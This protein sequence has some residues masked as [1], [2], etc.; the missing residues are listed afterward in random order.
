MAEAEPKTEEQSPPKP[1]KKLP[2]TLI[3]VVGVAVVEAAVF[4][5]VMKSMGGGPQVAHGAEEGEHGVIEGEDPTASEATAEIELL[6][7][8]RAPNRKG[9]RPMIF[10]MD[11]YLKVLS[12]RKTDV[13]ALIAERTG[14]IR[15]RIARVIRGADPEVLYEPE[16]RTIRMQLRHTIGDLAED[17]ELVQEVLV[18]RCVPMRGD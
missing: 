10:D 13:E 5:F 14:E 16:L 11:V 7:N 17:P 3:L 1:K 4:F 6:T 8:F 18:P 9:G 15:D 2:M 12:S